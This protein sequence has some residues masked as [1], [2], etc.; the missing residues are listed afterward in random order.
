MNN[1]WKKKHECVSFVASN[2]WTFDWRSCASW[3]AY[4][5]R[6]CETLF[7]NLFYFC[8]DLIWLLIWLLIWFWF[9]FWFL[10]DLIIDFWFLIWLLIWLLIFY[11]FKFDWSY[12]NAWLFF[13]QNFLFLN[14]F[15]K[16]TLHDR[17]LLN[18]KLVVVE[19]HIVNID[20]VIG[21]FLVNVFG[22]LRFQLCIVKL[23]VEH[24][25][26]QKNNCQCHWFVIIFSL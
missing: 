3:I 15:L 21:W 10:I 12:V 26:C 1:N 7:G 22:A 11:S 18:W 13:S 24:S 14:I 8:F 23:I 5:K 9:D 25:Q 2:E 19:R 17:S 20:C 4:R 6:I 16:K